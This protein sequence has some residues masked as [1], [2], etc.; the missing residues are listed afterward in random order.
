MDATASMNLVGVFILLVFVLFGDRGS[1]ATW[2]G[3]KGGKW[4]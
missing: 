3:G 2:G 4:V 1:K